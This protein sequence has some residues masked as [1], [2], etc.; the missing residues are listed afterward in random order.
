MLSYV[1]YTVFIWILSWF[2]RKKKNNDY[3]PEV[4]LLIAAYNEKDILQSKLNNTHELTYPKDKLKVLWVTD[5]SDDGTYEFLKEQ[6]DLQVE[7]HSK[8]NGK[9]GAVNRGMSFVK[10]KYTVFSDANSMLNKDCIQELV[11]GFQN[12]E[13]GCI[14]GKK[15]V[16]KHKKDQ[17]VSVGESVYWSIESK[18]KEYESIVNSTVGAAGELY[19]IRT[20]LFETI[21]DDTIIEDFVISVMMVK[22]GYKIKYAPGAFSVETSSENIGEELKRKT[23]IA[24]GGIQ[25]LLRYP[26]LLNPLKTGFFAF[27]YFFHKVLRWT[28][29]PFAIPLIYI[30]NGILMYLSNPLVNKSLVNEFLLYFFALQTCFFFLAINGWLL[31]NIKIKLNLLFI[32]Y[33]ILVMNFAIISGYIRY[34]TSSQS[35]NWEKAARQ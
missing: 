4:T 29:V 10:T 2:V 8:R 1:C 22:K 18:I 11:R 14:A 33:Y 5:G 20:E 16:I 27:Q 28:I 3:F 9:T 21:P 17:A 32:P 35:V 30:I 13:I 15:L 6:S 19:A 34:L 25:F 24:Y 23:R 12:P 7:H 31:R 26:E